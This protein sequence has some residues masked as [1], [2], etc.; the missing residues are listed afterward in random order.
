MASRIM[1]LLRMIPRWAT[2][3]ISQPKAHGAEM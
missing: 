2:G 3:E 1:A